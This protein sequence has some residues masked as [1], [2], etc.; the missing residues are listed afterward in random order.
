VFESEVLSIIQGIAGVNYVELD[1]MGA[2]D[3]DLILKAFDFITQ[4]P[5]GD[6]KK[7]EETF[8]DQLGLNG[9]KNVEIDLASIDKKATDPKKRIL[10]AQLA[11]LTPDIPDTLILTELLT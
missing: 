4:N 6:P 7:D 1:V 2:V 3:Q 8:L 9:H 11:F 10:P 5:Q